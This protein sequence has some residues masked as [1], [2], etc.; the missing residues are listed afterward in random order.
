ME[1]LESL[2][3]VMT[4]D[5][6]PFEKMSDWEPLTHSVLNVALDGRPMME[7]IPDPEPLEHSVLVIAL[8]G[9]LT[10]GMSHL[11]PIEHS[12]LNVALVALDLWRGPQIWYR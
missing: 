10:E 8:D 5:D 9:E 2:V 11:E 12:V 1:P 7:G 6:G 4:L 3:L